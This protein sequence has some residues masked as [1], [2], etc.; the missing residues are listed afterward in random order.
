MKNRTRNAE[1]AASTL[2]IVEAGC[3]QNRHGEQINIAAALTAAVEDTQLLTARESLPAGS[4]H[5]MAITVT[6]E[7]TL[8]ACQR[9]ATASSG[10]LL[11]LNFASAKNPGGGFLGGAQAQEESLARS[12]ALYPCL[13]A[14]PE[15]YEAHRRERSLLYS[16]RMILSP[17]VPVFRNDDGDL[18]DRPYLVTILTSPAPNVG[19]MRDPEEKAAVPEV[20]ARRSEKVLAVAASRGYRR[21]V[22][23]AWGCGVFRND[24]AEVAAVFAGHLRTGVFTD[25]F[26]EVVFA[27]FDPSP[28]RSTLAAFEAALS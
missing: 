5:R 12:S 17:A 8:E 3:Y 25:Q 21:V 13:Q 1:I 2:E 19:A 16:D 24:P 7:T 27:V 18:L 28:A 10:P 4:T 9:L 20:L 23:G 22:L 26:E 6:G 11:C 14:K 15:F